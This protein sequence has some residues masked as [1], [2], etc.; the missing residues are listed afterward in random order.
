MRSVYNCAYDK[1]IAYL[2]VL[3]V[4]A[5]AVSSRSAFQSTVYACE[6]RPQQVAFDEVNRSVRGWQAYR[7]TRRL[8]IICNQ[9]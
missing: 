9:L 2:A 7:N 8:D 3:I 6:G 5:I 4:Y 1:Q